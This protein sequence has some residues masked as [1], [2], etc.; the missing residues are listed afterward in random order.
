[1]VNDPKIMNEVIDNIKKL[2]KEDLENAMFEADKELTMES[3]NR[4]IQSI[5]SEQNTLYDNEDYYKDDI[6]QNELTL[7][8]LR[9]VIKIVDKQ[10]EIIK[11]LK[12]SKNNERCIQNNSN[13]I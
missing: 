11:N 4:Y 3:F 8:M 1:M 2:S 5:E 10:A 13:G 6:E 7:L 9:K 12:E